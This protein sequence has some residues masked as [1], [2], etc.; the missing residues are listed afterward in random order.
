[1][2]LFCAGTHPFAQWSA[3]KLTDAPRYAAPASMRRD[4]APPVSLGA[5]AG[6]PW[7][8]LRSEN[9]H[10]ARLNAMRVI[11]KAVPYD[12]RATDLSFV[13]DP[14]VVI[15]GAHE[16]ELMEA[17]RAEPALALTDTLA[18]I[19]NRLPATATTGIFGSMLRG[20][21]FVTSNVPGP[22]VPVNVSGSSV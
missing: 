9:K 4:E 12:D 21:D 22:P 14:H 8:I 1:M 2:E 15:S 18:G 3:A 11:L 19:L 20:I 17:Q 16:L 5:P 13:P 7:T 6:S 10:L